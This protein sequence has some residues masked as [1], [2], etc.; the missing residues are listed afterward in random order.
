MYIYYA[1]LGKIC[2]PSVKITTLISKCPANIESMCQHLPNE[3]IFWPNE[4]VLIGFT[5][6]RQN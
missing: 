2:A 6:V 4:N 5:L 1:V 3:Y